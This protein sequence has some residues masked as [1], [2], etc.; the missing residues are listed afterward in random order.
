MKS[1]N[2]F[3]CACLLLVGFTA[4][5]Q[6]KSKSS[7]PAPQFQEEL[8]SS[9]KWRSIG[10]YRGDRA[11]TVT[12]VVGNRSLYYMGTAGGGVWKT[13]DAGNTWECISDGYFG[14]SIGAVAVSELD[15][16]VIYVGEGEQTLR[17][18]VSSGRGLWKSTDAGESWTFIG[19]DQSEHIARIRIHPTNPDIVYVA[20]IGNLWKPN[21]QRGVF[22]SVD[23]GK[24]WKKILYVSDKAGA[25][26]LILDPNNPRIIYA[27][28]WQ[29][30]R[31]GYRMDSGGPDSKI[32]KSKDSGETW[33]ELSGNDG[34]PKGPWGIVGLA[35]SPVNSRRV[36]AIIEAEDGGVFRSDDSGKTWKKS[37]QI[38]H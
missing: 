34:L 35:V 29:M 20:A 27:A 8:Y 17:G 6:R 3:L 9:L 23:G 30:K 13:E 21:T 19:L 33:E 4:S 5:S 25:G 36:F 14:G 12:G 22:K 32:F 7:A 18:N 16:N 2:L 15:P 38:A 11:G 26:D 24:S 31:N 28:S 1:F 10:P 37:I